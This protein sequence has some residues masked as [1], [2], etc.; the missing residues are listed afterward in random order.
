MK[1][2]IF[3]PQYIDRVPLV[4]ATLLKFLYRSLCSFVIFIAPALAGRLRRASFRPF[5][6]PSVRQSSTFI[7]G[8][9]WAKLLLQF[10]TDQFE[11]LQVFSSWSEGVHVVW[12]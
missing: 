3:H 6:C 9:L 5:V 7:L 4:S 11:T 1:L 10:C 12:I 2:V 8:V